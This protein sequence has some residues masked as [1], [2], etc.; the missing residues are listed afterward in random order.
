MAA[1]VSSVDQAYLSALSQLRLFVRRFHLLLEYMQNELQLLIAT[2]NEHRTRLYARL[3]RHPVLRK[4]SQ[5][6]LET[7][8]RPYHVRM[9]IPT[10]TRLLYPTGNRWNT[11]HDT[12]W[13]E[14]EEASEPMI[15]NADCNPKQP[16]SEL[17]FD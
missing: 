17:L 1:L 12:P 13:A 6:K 15:C 14:S 2:E 11:R 3:L 10:V 8:I 9:P 16:E 5:V 7:A 4:I